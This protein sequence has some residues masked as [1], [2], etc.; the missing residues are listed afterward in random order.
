[1]KTSVDAVFHMHLCKPLHPLKA[2]ISDF[3]L[4]QFIPRLWKD[5]M[6]V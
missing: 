4:T 1:M 2:S 5:A 6:L 3:H